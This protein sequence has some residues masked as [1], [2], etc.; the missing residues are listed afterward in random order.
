MLKAP[1][2][3]SSLQPAIT[4]TITAN[5]QRSTLKCHYTLRVL[6]RKGGG[7]AVLGVLMSVGG[8]HFLKMVSC[9]HIKFALNDA[10]TL[11]ETKFDLYKCMMRRHV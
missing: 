5:P 8:G 3:N 10:Q 11:N 9:S 6:E 7:G 1:G 4:N 2:Y